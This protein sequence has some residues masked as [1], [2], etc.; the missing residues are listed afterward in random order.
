MTIAATRHVNNVLLG[1]G[2][3]YIDLLD[4]DDNPTGERYLGDAVSFS[5]ATTVERAQVFSGTGQVGRKMV[6]KVRSQEHT[7]SITVRDVSLPNLALLLGG[8]APAEVE[9][10]ATAVTDEEITVQQGRWYQLGATKAKPTGAR[11]VGD[12]SVTVTDKDDVAIVAADNWT[13]DAAR[14]RIHI[15]PGGAI[16]DGDKIKVDYTP[17]AQKRQQVQVGRI[18]DVRAAVR[19]IEDTGTGEGR[20]YFAPLCSISGGGEISLMSRETEQQVQLSCQ[21]LDPGGGASALL[22]DGEPYKAA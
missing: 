2:E 12:K 9:D 7:I 22:V 21:I 17:V 6:D 3:V 13:L 5:V 19:Y 4:A 16:S 10:E 20:D 8:G 11:A 18:K 1:S 15:E 14:G